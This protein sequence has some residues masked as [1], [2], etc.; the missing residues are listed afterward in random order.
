MF[1]NAKNKK[2]YIDDTYIDY[3]T[4]GRGKKNLV[5]I[6]GL[7][8]TKIGGMAVPMAMLYRKFAKEYTVYITDRRAV[9]PAGCTI[10]D[11]AADTI[12]LLKNCGVES[13]DFVGVSQ[14]GMIA[15]RIAV[16]CPDIVESLVLTVTSSSSNGYISSLLDRWIDMSEKQQYREFTADMMEK[17]YSE[18]YI[19]KYRFAMPLITLMQKPKNNDRFVIQSEAI[20][21]FDLYDKISSIRCPALVIAGRKD[22]VIPVEL[23]V[24][25]AEKLGCEIY[26]YEKYGHALYD[27]ASD[28]IDRV[29]EFL[30]K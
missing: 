25:T 28:F 1:Y 11:M 19:S 14:G 15:Q 13:A 9:L 22:K 26:V 20:K 17:M 24:Q 3:L 7:G 29:L 10:E 16:L 5:I 2:F 21:R 18:E 12:S 6:P 23:S 8:T 4:F 30:R 27:E